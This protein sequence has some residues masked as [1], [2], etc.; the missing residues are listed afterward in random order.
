MPSFK[1][2]CRGYIV[3]LLQTALDIDIDGHFGRQTRAAVLQLQ[4]RMMM[5][6]TGEANAN[7]FRALK[8]RW[9]DQFDRCLQVCATF[10]GTGF[11]GVNNTDIDGAGVTLGMAGFTTK[12]GE[13]QQLISAYVRRHP[14]ALNI[15]PA[16]M[17]DSLLKLIMGATQKEWDDWFYSENG[18]LKIQVR[19]IVK[20]WGRDP[21][22]QGLQL[23]RIIEGFWKPA[24]KSGLALGL[25]TI[26]GFGLML[27]IQ[28]Q[29]GGW[30]PAHQQKFLA[31]SMDGTEAS[32]LRA[33]SRVVADSSNPRWKDDVLTRK[34]VFAT[35]AGKVHGSF[36]NLGNYGFPPLEVKV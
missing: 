20:Q 15:V 18:R 29:N 25:Q 2:G 32:K 23:E 4:H 3:E 28:I 14:S 6:Q 16:N 17:R 11:G 27:D 8:L 5:E 33:I 12:H 19:D 9:P 26:H 13:V 34:M 36:F 1:V 22:F 30:R 24:V 35:G 21:A 31:E 10:E 7:V